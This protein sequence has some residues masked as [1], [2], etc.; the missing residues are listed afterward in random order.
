MALDCCFHCDINTQKNKKA[1]SKSMSSNNE[2]VNSD[3]FTT[4]TNDRRSCMKKTKHFLVQ[5]SKS[6][7]IFITRTDTNQSKSVYWKSLTHL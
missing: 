6:H 3:I 1:K 5:P 4:C 7:I 2:I